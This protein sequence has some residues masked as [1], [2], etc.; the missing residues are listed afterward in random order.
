MSIKITAYDTIACSGFKTNDIEEELSK[1]YIQNNLKPL[2]LVSSINAY[3]EDENNSVV[4]LIEQDDLVRK[5]NH[6][7]LFKTTKKDEHRQ[8]IKELALDCTFYGRYDKMKG[9]YI[10]RNASEY[11]FHLNRLK[12]NNYLISN[13]VENLRSLS[14]VPAGVYG[15]LL[16]QSIT[17]RFALNYGEQGMINVL[18]IYFYYCLFTDQE[19]FEDDL[20]YSKII[21]YISRS[22][23]LDT[24]GI[25]KVLDFLDRKAIH[26]LDEL[27]KVIVDKLQNVVIKDLSVGILFAICKDNWYGYNSKETLLVGLEH[28]PTWLMMVYAS[29]NEATFKRSNLARISAIYAKG[30]NGDSFIKSIQTIL[31]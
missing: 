28:I 19:K 30:S 3:T 27:C 25:M 17:R 31:R 11:E 20:E 24:E 18:A 29:I 5:F 14:F 16:A 22:S 10:L 8:V 1:A 21:K 7:L 15:S 4:H 26:S 6:P 13:P 12:L 9:E 23:R 2:K